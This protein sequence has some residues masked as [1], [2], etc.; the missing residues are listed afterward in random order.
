MA[1]G[2]HGAPAGTARRQDTIP[3]RVASGDYSLSPRILVASFPRWRMRWGACR[4]KPETR[5]QAVLAPARSSSRGAPKQIPGGASSGQGKKGGT[6]AAFPRWANGLVDRRAQGDEKGGLGVAAVNFF[7]CHPASFVSITAVAAWRTRHGALRPVKMKD[8][9][10][11]NIFSGAPIAA[12]R[13]RK[14]PFVSG[15]PASLG[16]HSRASATAASTRP[17]SVGGK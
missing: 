16:T 2:R 14:K 4:A 7:G 6:G 13:C 9:L 11:G 1:R 15:F 17:E 3:R 5:K 12:P 10:A 8:S